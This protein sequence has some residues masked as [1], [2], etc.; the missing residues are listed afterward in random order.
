MIVCALALAGPHVDR[1]IALRL[2]ALKQVGLVIV[3]CVWVS[4]AAAVALDVH[5]AAESEAIVEEA[6]SAAQH[7]LG[8]LAILVAVERVGEGNT[9]T[10]VAV[11]RNVILRLPAQAAG[12]SQICVGLPVVL[13]EERTV[14]HAARHGVRR[15]WCS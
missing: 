15:R 11:I 6:V 10:P 8:L 5:Q 3:F 4:G 12:E 13:H 2:V 1:L 14:K 9:R 7:G